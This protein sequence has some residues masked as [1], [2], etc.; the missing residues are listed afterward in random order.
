[1][2]ILVYLTSRLPLFK[3]V[4]AKAVLSVYIRRLIHFRATWYD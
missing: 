2:V 4:R 1:M 3:R